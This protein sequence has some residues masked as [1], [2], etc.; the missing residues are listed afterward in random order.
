MSDEH[1]SEEA[2]QY[3]LKEAQ[4][5]GQIPKSIELNGWLLVLISLAYFF[6]FAEQLGTELMSNISHYLQILSYMD[7][8]N[9]Y[10]LIAKEIF[11]SLAVLLVPFFLI[12]ILSTVIINVLFNGFI[13]S[14][15]PLTPKFEKMNPIKGLKK[16]FSKK[17]LFELVKQTVKLSSVAACCYLLSFGVIEKL[18]FAS[19]T[20]VSSM[21]GLTLSQEALRLGFYILAVTLPLVLLDVLFTRWDFKKQMMMSSREVKDEYKK[22]EGDPQIKSKRKE[23]QKELAKKLIALGKVKDADIVINNPTHIAVAIKF[24]PKTMIAPIVVASGRGILGK[25]IRRIAV[26]HSLMQI[27]NISLARRLYKQVGIGQ[28]L[29]AEYFDEF[30]PIY[31]KIL[32]MDETK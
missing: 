20:L 31:R 7:I 2:S 25:F 21:L 28:P 13:F 17:N 11:Y 3:K 24:D 30:A 5:R 27:T 1:K 16:I 12:L 29:P 26:K 22:K 15:E 8:S 32:G 6:L 4:K 10:L 14:F 23:V 19:Q 9:D 18:L